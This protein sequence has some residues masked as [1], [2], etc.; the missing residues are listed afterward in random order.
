MLLGA[1]T[2]QGASPHIGDGR[3]GV[4]KHKVGSRVYV[5]ALGEGKVYKLVPK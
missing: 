2:A 3:G 4:R 1:V 5:A